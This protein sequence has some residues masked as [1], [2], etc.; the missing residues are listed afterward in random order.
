[1]I[2]AGLIEKELGLI[3]DDRIERIEKMLVKLGLPT[4]IN[5]MGTAHPTVKQ[6]MDLMSLDKKAVG[7]WPRFVLL[8]KL[9]QVCCRDGQWAQ[10]VPRKTIEQCLG[11]LV[12]K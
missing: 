12:Q 5:S 1:M 6:L 3:N 10:E 2:A 11:Q 4:R 7:K 9:G 8:E